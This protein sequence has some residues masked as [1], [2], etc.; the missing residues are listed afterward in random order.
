M[1]YFTSP[2][3]NSFITY[4]FFLEPLTPWLPKTSP[5]FAAPQSLWPA[6][7]FLY[8]SYIFLAH[9]LLNQ[10]SPCT[11]KD[12]NLSH[13]LMILKFCFQVQTYIFSC[14]LSISTWLP[15]RH[16][17]LNAKKQ[18]HHLFPKV[19]FPYQIPNPL[20]MV[21]PPARKLGV[22]T[23]ASSYLTVVIKTNYKALLVLSHY[24]PSN[25]SLF[26]HFHFPTLFQYL[27]FLFLE[28]Y[29]LFLSKIDLLRYNWQK[30]HHLKDTIQWFLAYLQSCAIITI[31]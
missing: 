26:L 21:P 27:S 14:L 13:L 31:V 12:S 30:N 18:T 10:H 5:H 8:N 29:K 15:Q 16:L 25:P 19:L 23:Y 1:P 6:T 4:S 7:L 28:Y 9:F 24:W 2:G 3:L 22:T 20:W 17:K 11:Y